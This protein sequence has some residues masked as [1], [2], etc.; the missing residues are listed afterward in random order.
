MYEQ[1]F[2][3]YIRLDLTGGCMESAIWGLIGTVIGAL[4]SIGTTWISSRTAERLHHA[5]ASAERTERSDSFQVQTLVTLQDT[6][7]EYLRLVTRAFIE[8]H[9]SQQ[10]GHTWGKQYLSPEVNDGLATHLRKLAILI[11]RVSN[12]Q[13]RMELKAVVQ[14][15]T[16]VSFAESEQDARRRLETSKCSAARALEKLGTELRARYSPTLT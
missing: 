11:E 9:K 3:F 16:E 13:V 6:M 4:A 7:H 8:D 2:A 10:D 5:K 15:T 12:E 14:A 1:S